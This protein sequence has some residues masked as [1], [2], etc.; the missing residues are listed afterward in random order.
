[1]KETFMAV[2]L[3]AAMLPLAAKA[4]GPI[5]KFFVAGNLGQ[6]N[7]RAGFTHKNGVFQGINAGWRWDGILGAEI[8]YACLGRA[9]I[10]MPGESGSQ[11]SQ[12]GT[13]GLNARYNFL[14]NWYVSGRTGY[15]RVRALSERVAG[16]FSGKT[17]RWNSGWYRGVGVGYNMTRHASLGLNYDNYYVEAGRKNDGPDAT[18]IATYS[19]RFEYR[20]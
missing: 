8:G 7:P 10:R 3:V 18:T 9:K 15:A 17:S 16:N 6:S 12:A 2:A 19:V 4:D 14:P 1:M 20:I 5:N 13:A 11:Q